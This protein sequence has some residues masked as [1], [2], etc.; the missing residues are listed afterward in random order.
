MQKSLHALIVA[1][2]QS[3]PADFEG[4]LEQCGHTFVRAHDVEQCVNRLSHELFD[5]LFL[6]PDLKDLDCEGLLRRMRGRK[7]E[8]RIVLVS[9]TDD[10][11]VIER[12]LS[13]GAH[14]HLAHP[15]EAGALRELFR[16]WESG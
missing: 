4:L 2:T 15:V 11:G 8:T 3:I 14:A 1:E 9:E 5:V 6:D 12:L 13:A 7:P 10:K 16:A